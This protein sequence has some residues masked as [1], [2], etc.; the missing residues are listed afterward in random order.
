[1]DNVKIGIRITAGFFALL[2][3]MVS[4]AGVRYFNVNTL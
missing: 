1:M 2:L 4:L 3:M